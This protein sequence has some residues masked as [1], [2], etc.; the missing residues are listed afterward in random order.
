MLVPIRIDLE[1]DVFGLL[2]LHNVP[3]VLHLAYLVVSLTVR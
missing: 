1:S 3:V 2:T